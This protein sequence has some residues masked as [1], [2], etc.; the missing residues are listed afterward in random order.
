MGSGKI[1]TQLRAYFV[2]TDMCYN[3]ICIRYKEMF[4]KG[5]V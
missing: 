2:E 3:S 1:G 4:V 5:V